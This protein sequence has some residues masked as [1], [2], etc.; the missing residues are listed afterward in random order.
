MNQFCTA[1]A[2][3]VF[4]TI[5]VFFAG[6]IGRV[7]YL[8]TI[9]REQTIRKA[10]RQQHQTEPLFARRGSIFDSTGMLMAGTVQTRTL[11]ADPKFMQDEYQRNGH[12]LVELDQLIAKLAAILDKDPLELSQLLGDKYAS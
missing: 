7:G 1:R 12:S 4:A 8:Q 6:L 9:G 11:F 3:I 5:G 2:A 10:E